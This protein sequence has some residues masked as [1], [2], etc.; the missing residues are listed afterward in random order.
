MTSIAIVK[1][2][3]HQRATCRRTL[4]AILLIFQYNDKL[5][6]EAVFNAL[7][8]EKHDK[9]DIGVELVLGILPNGASYILATP[10]QMNKI[11]SYCRGGRLGRGQLA[12]D[13]ASLSPIHF[14]SLSD[15]ERKV[16]SYLQKA[17]K[18]AKAFRRETVGNPVDNSQANKPYFLGNSAN[19]SRA[20]FEHQRS[21][22]H[23]FRLHTMLFT[24]L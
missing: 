18:G 21:V 15:L 4:S 16:R 6:C 14:R 3:A 1:Y 9:R 8:D 13:Y 23:A 19:T 20:N 22:W 7:S 10:A 24:Q 17:R 5:L 12:S 11:S 2:G